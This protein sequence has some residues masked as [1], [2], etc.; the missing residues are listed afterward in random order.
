[1]TRIIA[2]LIT[3]SITGTAL[4]GCPT[5]QQLLNV[6]VTRYYVEVIEADCH[7]GSDTVY[8]VL[9]RTIMNAAAEE[10]DPAIIVVVLDSDGEYWVEVLGMVPGLDVFVE[11]R[12]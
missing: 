6:A 4:A 3:M 2:L 5:P 9:A 11:D 7:T 8:P 10:K 12:K 1:M